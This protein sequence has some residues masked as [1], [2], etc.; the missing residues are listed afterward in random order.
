MGRSEGTEDLNPCFISGFSGYLIGMQEITSRTSRG[1]SGAEARSE[2]VPN[3]AELYRLLLD[4]RSLDD[5][6]HGL[7]RWASDVLA[8]HGLSC[9]IAVQRPRRPML[10]AASDGATEQLMSVW[11]A[12]EGSPLRSVLSESISVI[13]PDGDGHHETRSPGELLMALPIQLEDEGSAALVLLG[14]APEPE[15]HAVLG[16][17]GECRRG[18]AWTLR[19]AARYAHQAEL[20]EHRAAA[21][22]NRTIIDLAIGVIM[23]QN[24]CSPEDAFEILKRASN[25]RNRKL[26]EVAK[27]VVASVTSSEVE[28]KFDV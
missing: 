12:R 17:V 25:A 11:L 26:S 21:M 27:G 7:V 28:T 9:G 15:T 23:G 10:T 20:A 5:V 6:A 13:G 16:V 4:H 3:L 22:E 19:L 14:Q 24:R 1:E 18:V 8:E 2:G